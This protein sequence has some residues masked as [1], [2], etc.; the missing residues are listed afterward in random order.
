MYIQQAAKLH[1][2]FYLE[3]CS[4]RFGW[5]HHPSSGTQTIVSTTSAVCHTVM[6]RVK[7][8]DKVYLKIRF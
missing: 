1:S 5:Y 8:T 3:N 4:T 2:L 6:E 7:F